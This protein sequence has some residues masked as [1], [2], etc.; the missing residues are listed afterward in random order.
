MMGLIALAV[1]VALPGYGLA[2]GLLT[3]VIRG[4]GRY[5]RAQ[6]PV[7]YWLR[8]AFYAF[9]VAAVGCLGLAYVRAVLQR[10]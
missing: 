7:D 5:S 1:L 9:I 3:G 6:E 10:I 8:V 2:E 4:R